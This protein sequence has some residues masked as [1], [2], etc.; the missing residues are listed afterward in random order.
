M[1]I[2]AVIS[3]ALGRMGGTV[4]RIVS[5]AHDL[6]LVGGIDVK[7][8]SLFGTEVVPATEIDAFLKEKKP[9]VLIDF[10]LRPLRLRTSKQQQEIMC[11]GSWDNRVFAGTAKGDRERR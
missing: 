6:E 9:D 5:E 8:G 2:K 4:G 1:A 7:K 11:T 10:S 3:G